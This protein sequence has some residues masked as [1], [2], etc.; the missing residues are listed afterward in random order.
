[1]NELAARL[2]TCRLFE[3]FSE[4]ELEYLASLAEVQHYPPGTTVIHQGDPGDAFYVVLSGHLEVVQ[5]DGKGLER[6][7]NYHMTG[8]YFGEGALFTGKPRAATVRAMDDVELAVFD[9]QAFAQLGSRH[10]DLKRYLIRTRVD[11]PGRQPDEVADVHARR[12]PYA[13]IER[14]F[15]PVVVLVLWV[16]ITFGLRVLPRSPLRGVLPWAWVVFSVLWL[17]VAVLLYTDWINDAFIVST[18]RVIHI[19]KVFFLREE[20]HEAPIDQVLSVSMETPSLTALIFG[21]GTLDIHTASLGKPIVFDHLA[22]AERI[23]Q[24]ILELRDR[25][26]AYRVTAEKG[27]RRR[28]L[29]EQLGLRKGAIEPP[30]PQPPPTPKPKSKGALDYI[31]NYFVPHMVLKKPGEITWRKHWYILV[32]KVILPL[33]AL[34]LTA[35]LIIASFPPFLLFGQINK[36]ALFPYFVTLSTILFM[37]LLGWLWWR[38]EDWHNDIYTVTE[39]T[40]IDRESLPF[41]F[42]EQ[43]RVGSLEDIE[44]VY[45]RVPNFLA[46]LINMGDVVIDTAGSPEAA[47]TFKS[48]HDPIAVQ[49]EIFSRIYAYHERKSKRETQSEMERWA[50]WF[51]EYHRLTSGQGQQMESES[52]P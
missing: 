15:I 19:E 12:H 40:I 14:F 28:I 31:L 8:Q 9:K 13:V 23:Q 29:E 6:T 11:F 48:V 20:R 51:S 21:F 50:D 49:Q 45:S 18:K 27:Q 41:G 43:K 37:S 47:Y 10:P 52:H 35:G 33:L 24:V 3:K 5:T 42:R 22:E 46:R 7:I 2:R 34:S 32:K 38:Y 17:L 36:S 44:S 26:R 1:M 25:A 16:S 30:I 4:D 39:T